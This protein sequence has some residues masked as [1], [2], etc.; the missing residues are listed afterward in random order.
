[1]K[2]LKSLP[3]LA[4]AIIAALALSIAA[5][6]ESALSPN[7]CYADEFW[8]GECR[9]ADDWTAGWYLHPD[10]D[11]GDGTAVGIAY[12][13][14][15][16]VIVHKPHSMCI[17]WRTANCNGT[18]PPEPPEAKEESR[19]SRKL[20]NSVAECIAQANTRAKIDPYCQA[21]YSYDASLSAGDAG[22]NADLE[23]D[24]AAFVSGLT[25]QSTCILAANFINT[26]GAGYTA[27][28]LDD[29]QAAQMRMDIVTVQ[30]WTCVTHY[31]RRP[32][33]IPNPP[34]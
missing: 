7:I 19:R 11:P 10:N 3:A 34:S 33:S 15:A 24:R 9:S 6:A 30:S 18:I 2:H 17:D 5:S 1:M 16:H 13:N 4:L 25:A 23:T 27:G 8:D 12:A 32:P 29:S 22:Y 31:N 14:F 20:A 21:L 26:N 28:N